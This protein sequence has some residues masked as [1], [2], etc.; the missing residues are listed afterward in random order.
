MDIQFFGAAKMV[1]GSNYLLRTKDY[2]VL[3]DCGMFQGSNEIERMNTMPF[4]Y[5]PKEIDLVLVPGAAFDLDGFRVGYGGG[6]YDR[7]L[8][9]K[10]RQDI[11]KIAESIFK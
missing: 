6:Y 5:D 3:I 8:S 4:P 7:F 11:I 2:K 9:V 10:I 1:T